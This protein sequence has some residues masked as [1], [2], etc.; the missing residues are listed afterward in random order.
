MDWKGFT[1][2]SSAPRF[3]ALNALAASS[4]PRE[5]MIGISAYRLLGL[6]YFQEFLTVRWAY[7][8]P[9]MIRVC[10][11]TFFQPQHSFG[12]VAFDAPH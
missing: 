3:E 2:K 10:V 5:I 9:A 1:I 6:G 7:A 11:I 8:G 12:A 4:E